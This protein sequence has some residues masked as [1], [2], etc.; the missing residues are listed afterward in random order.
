MSNKAYMGVSLDGYIATAS[1]GL[2]WLNEVP[3]PEKSDFGYA[4]FMDSVD[5]IVMGRN[6]YETVLSFGQ[7]PYEKPVFVLSR[8]LE[9][10]TP[11]L[12][13]QIEILEGHP[14]DIVRVL[15]EHGYQNLYIDGGSVVQDFLSEGMLDEIT[16][17][18]VPILLGGG[19]SLFGALSEPIRLA[20]EGTTVYKNGLVKSKYSIVC[21]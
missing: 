13:K 1:N 11:E 19:I 9:Q 4:E 5:A 6:T 3:N 10:V 17:T 20:H 12:E 7:W 16:T 21:D 18:H 8:T 2:D 14:K 15:N